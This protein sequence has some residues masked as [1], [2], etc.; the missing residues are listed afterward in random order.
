[1]ESVRSTCGVS[2][3]KPSQAAPV[4]TSTRTMRAAAIL[5]VSPIAFRC[6]SATLG[7]LGS[8]PAFRFLY[9]AIKQTHLSAPASQTGP[10]PFRS[11]PGDEWVSH[12]QI[13]ANQPYVR[14]LRR[15]REYATRQTR[16]E[17]P[18]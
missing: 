16:F 5:N 12:R 10:P 11:V 13:A 17:I 15:G 9:R 2:R 6:R 8:A 18:D 7:D 3:L 1:M 4:T 14:H